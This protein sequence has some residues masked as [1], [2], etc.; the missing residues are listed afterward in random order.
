MYERAPYPPSLFEVT[1]NMRKVLGQEH[2]WE[3]SDKLPE[4]IVVCIVDAM[5]FVQKRQ[6]LKYKT[7]S[8]LSENDLQQLL[9]LVS[10]GCENVHFVADRYDL[11]L[12]ESLK[13]DEG[14]DGDRTSHRALRF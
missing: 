10:E 6:D 14:N 5:A 9:S 11:P 2:L 13:A 3:S 7:F 12:T 8:E 4:S 1:G